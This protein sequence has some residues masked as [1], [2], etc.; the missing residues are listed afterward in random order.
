MATAC[1]GRPR[2][3]IRLTVQGNSCGIGRVRRRLHGRQCAGWAACGETHTTPDRWQPH[4]R[5]AELGRT[6][7]AAW[8]GRRV[9]CGPLST[10]VV[11][12][13]GPKQKRRYMKLADSVMECLSVPSNVHPPTSVPMPNSFCW[14]P[15]HSM[16]TPFAFGLWRRPRRTRIDWD[17]RC[18]RTAE[19]K[20][21]RAV[22]ACAARAAGLAWRQQAPL[23]GRR[24]SPGRTRADAVAYA[25]GFGCRAFAVVHQ[26]CVAARRRAAGAAECGTR[27]RRQS[28]VRLTSPRRSVTHGRRLPRNDR[29]GPRPP[30]QPVPGC[31]ES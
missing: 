8:T 7:R 17:R 26:A 4:R 30:T 18:A 16:I 21:A 14:H 9:A 12:R 1:E 13:I 23:C 31:P 25:T 10:Y 6:P 2:W 15:R 19:G 24:S 20:P 27:C 29:A 11:S 22:R 28:V 3:A 5:Q